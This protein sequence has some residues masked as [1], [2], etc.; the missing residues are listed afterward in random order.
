MEQSKSNSDK[1][2]L[3][4]MS[5][6]DKLPSEKMGL[7]KSALEKAEE[8][9]I[10]SIISIELKSPMTIFLLSWFIG[11]LSL[12]RFLLGSTGVGIA[13]LLTFQ[14]LGIWWLVDLITSMKRTKEYNF[15]K[16]KNYLGIF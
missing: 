14:G 8:S 4:L 11:W 1:I 2:N 16:I 12:D 5:S 7:L 9:K 10:D 15:L 13:R 3:W 6:Q